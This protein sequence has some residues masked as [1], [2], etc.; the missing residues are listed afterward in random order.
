MILCR[1]V[2]PGTGCRFRGSPQDAHCPC[3]PACLAHRHGAH[4]KSQTRGLVR[5]A[6]PR[7]NYKGWMAALRM[8]RSVSILS[9][10]LCHT[11]RVDV[12]N[13]CW[14][15]SFNKLQWQSEVGKNSTLHRDKIL[16]L[17]ALLRLGPRSTD[18]IRSAAA[19]S[20]GIR[21][22]SSCPAWLC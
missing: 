5:Q 7:D 3:G 6:P 17:D 2:R 14:A 12:A 15:R 20:G 19:G 9:C 1:L 8:A 4:K 21:Y 22:S 16:S 13:Y 11:S 18:S 10:F